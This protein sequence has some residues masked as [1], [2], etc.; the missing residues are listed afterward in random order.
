MYFQGEIVIF[1]LKNG[2]LRIETEAVKCLQ[3]KHPEVHENVDLVKL[4]AK[5]QT[6]KQA[7]CMYAL[8]EIEKLE[9]VD[10]FVSQRLVFEVKNKS[11]SH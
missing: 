2:T 5:E 10:T 9:H 11:F 1:F 7:A 4:K 6:Y 8:S 3:Y